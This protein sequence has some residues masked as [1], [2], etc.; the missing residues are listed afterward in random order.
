MYEPN[1]SLYIP[2]YYKKY[3]T[4]NT[5]IRQFIEGVTISDTKGLKEMGLTAEL[6]FAHIMSEIQRVMSKFGL[7]DRKMNSQGVILR[8]Y[9]KPI[10][11]K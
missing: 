9:I 5:L 6:A 1:S 4:Q 2:Y 11:R 3:A 7:I 10:K 8:K